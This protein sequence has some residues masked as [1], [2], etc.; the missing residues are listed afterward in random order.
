[1]EINDESICKMFAKIIGGQE[2]F[3]GGKCMVTI[4]RDDINVTILKKRFRV[5][6]SF[7]FKSRDNSGRAL[8]L[9]RRVLL[10]KEVGGFV[11][12]LLN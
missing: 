1:M 12:A 3:D 4:I 10:Q 8:C 9:G 6:T 5:T 7:S 11:A 2:G